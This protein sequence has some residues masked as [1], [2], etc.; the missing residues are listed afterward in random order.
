MPSTTQLYVEETGTPGAPSIIFLHGIG[1]SG[2]MWSRQTAT[3]ADFH[4]LNVD[5]P[6]HGKSNQITWVSLADTTDQIATIIRTRATHAKAHIVGLSLGGYIA[7]LLLEHHADLLDRVVISGVTA[8]PMPNRAWLQPQLAVMTFLMKRR[9]IVEMQAR[10]LHLPPDMESAFTENLL[11]ASMTAYRTIYEEAVDFQVAPSNFRGVNIPTL[12]VAGGSES[13]IILQSVKAI[14]QMM[15][16][17]QGR[18]APGLRHG[19]N[20][21]NPDLFNRMVRA[22]LTCA[23]L[24]AELQLPRR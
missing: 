1:A 13:E 10:A 19:W 14:P 3:L 20:V 11:A 17:T 7:L 23:P 5:L 2:W 18:L 9:W 22:W 6:G 8:S 21:E 15:P 24:P 4:C 16:N 12:V